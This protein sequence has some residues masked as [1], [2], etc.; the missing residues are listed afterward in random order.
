[1]ISNDYEFFKFIL[2]EIDTSTLKFNI[3][4]LFSNNVKDNPS[5]QKQVIHEETINLI[6]KFKRKFNLKKF[7]LRRE[8]IDF[9]YSLIEKIIKSPLIKSKSSYNIT[10]KN[11]MP[12]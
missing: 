12:Y 3:H 4:L 2:K 11:L 7:Y 10:K 5:E 9:R 8:S 1:M 6:P